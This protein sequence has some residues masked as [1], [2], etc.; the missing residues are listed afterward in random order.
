VQR[1]RVKKT[2]YENRFKISKKIFGKKSP[3]LMGCPDSKK[4]FLEKFGGNYG[5][6]YLCKK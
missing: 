2:L 6:Y 3:Q 5:M 1:L 4:K